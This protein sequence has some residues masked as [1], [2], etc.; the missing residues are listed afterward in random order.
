MDELAALAGKDPVAFRQAHLAEERPAKSVQ[1]RLRAVLDEA[2][3]KFGWDQ[4]A[5]RRAPGTGVGVACGTEKGAFVATCADVEVDRESG[6]ITV[7]RIVQAFECGAVINPDNLTAQNLGSIVMALGPALR[8]EIRFEDG[9]VTTDAFSDYAVPRFADVPQI[10]VHLL[11]RTD[12]PSV[13]AGETP[14][15]TVAPAIA[16][17][18]FQA[19]GARLREMP[20]KLPKA[21]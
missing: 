12:L 16:N 17:A 1:G 15:I 13:G 9:R 5:K 3:S 7:R 10:E 14:L 21:V 4:L 2:T 18:V 8:E 20:M 19:T 6:K 11:N